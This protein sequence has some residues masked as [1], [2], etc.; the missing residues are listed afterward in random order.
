M[1][2]GLLI[3]IDDTLLRFKPGSEQKST[4][5]L[6]QV[7]RQAGTEL[8][9][10]PEEEVT[11]RMDR[12]KNEVSWWCWTD[13]IRELG[14]DPERFWDYAFALESTY[15]EAAEPGLPDL[16]KELRGKGLELFV[17]SNNPNAG[18]RHKLRLAGISGPEC[19]RLFSGLLGAT[20]MRQMK[21]DGEYWH[22]A[23]FHTG[24]SCREL[25]VVGDDLNDDY[26]VPRQA[27]LPHTFLLNR[28]GLYNSMPEQPG[29]T[30]IDSLAGLPDLLNST[31]CAKLPPVYA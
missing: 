31:T 2:K 28:K 12:V 8:A 21:W 7:L 9:G 16:L 10:L 22:R 20:E 3:D 17:T 15:L 4:G 24:L 14:I 5:S 23:C 25:A 13:F 6:M 27:G 11:K 26:K 18:I 1:Y 29:M 19:N 30:I